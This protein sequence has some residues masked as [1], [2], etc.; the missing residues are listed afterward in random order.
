MHDLREAARIEARAADQR[1]VDIG[2]RHE[3]A[4]I[5]GL[6]AAAV[7]D[8]NFVRGRL[9]GNFAEHS[10]NEGVRFLRLFR[11]RG[12]RNTRTSG[13]GWGKRTAR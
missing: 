8:P 10:P 9:I 5:V 6:H 2:L 3:R 13:F 11:R 1:A 7:L 12:S 4:R